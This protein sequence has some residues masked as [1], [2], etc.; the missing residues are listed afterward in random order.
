MLAE[1][2]NDPLHQSL[3]QECGLASCCHGKRQLELSDRACQ[4]SGLNLW[5]Q[6][7]M[8]AENKVDTSRK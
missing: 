6:G 2:V 5:Y 1:W 8:G 3:H 4:K 7:I